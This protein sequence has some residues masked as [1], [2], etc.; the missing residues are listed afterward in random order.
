[1]CHSEA[2]P[3]NLFWHL[4]ENPRPGLGFY[5]ITMGYFQMSISQKHIR[6]LH[7]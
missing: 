3:K 6:I 5:C 4:K 2:E 1:V 7:H